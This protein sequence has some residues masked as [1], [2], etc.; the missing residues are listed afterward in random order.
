MVRSRV[1]WSGEKAVGYCWEKE[2]ILR[3][4]VYLLISLGALEC[5]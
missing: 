4:T 5:G 1:E 3:T 2:E